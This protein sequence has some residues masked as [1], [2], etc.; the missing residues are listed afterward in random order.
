MRNL[1]IF[2]FLKSYLKNKNKLKRLPQFI[3]PAQP[4]K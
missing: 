2:N 4:D 1:K 3:N